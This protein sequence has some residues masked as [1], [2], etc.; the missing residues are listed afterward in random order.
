MCY[1]AIYY[2]EKKLTEHFGN[3]YLDFKKSVPRIFPVK[4]LKPYKE[5]IFAE[6]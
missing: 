6:Y 3:F 5:E 2:E 1:G 4:L